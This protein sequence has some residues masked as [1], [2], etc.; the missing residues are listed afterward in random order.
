MRTPQRSREK[1]ACNGDRHHGKRIPNGMVSSSEERELVPKDLSVV[2]DLIER[3][4]QEYLTKDQVV[5]RLLEC[6]K[7]EPT[8]T[9][10]VW[11]MME[12]E[13]R[14]FF[15]AYYARLL[16]IQQIKDLNKLLEKQWEL[17]MNQCGMQYI[18]PPSGHNAEG[19][20]IS[21][22]DGILHVP[23][24][25]PSLQIMPRN[26]PS[27]LQINPILSSMVN[28]NMA[29]DS[30]VLHANRAL[31]AA[32]GTQFPDH[33]PSPDAPGNSNGALQLGFN[34]TQFP[35]H[36][37][38]PDNIDKQVLG[39]NIANGELLAINGTQL[40]HIPSRPGNT[41]HTSA[42]GN[43][44]SALQLAFNGTQ[45][46]R[47]ISSNSVDTLLLGRENGA[48]F[49]GFNGP[50]PD[51]MHTSVLGQPNVAFLAASGTQFPQT[52]LPPYPENVDLP[53]DQISRM[54]IS[55][56]EANHRNVVSG[57]QSCDPNLGCLGYYDPS[58]EEMLYALALLPTPP[59]TILEL[60][61]PESR[62]HELRDPAF[63][64]G[65]KPDQN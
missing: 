30:R 3:S 14:D 43:S 46:P 27:A 16:L 32:D 9:T 8:L 37:P 53:V 26:D 59:A 62:A 60:E 18:H 65:A 42:P 24:N 28:S 11:E 47:T 29:D 38:S 56:A 49:L 10:G 63:Q 50:S 5:E 17:M 40:S 23:R 36:A 41:M 34:G 33:A 6:A 51:N 55:D 22:W 13:N 45:F 61:P 15:R 19:T 21:G 64:P 31:A 57:E 1:H 4:I 52:Q 39:H 58:T 54:G 48:P 20:N 7:I 25:G 12:E 44:N 2:Q 35:D